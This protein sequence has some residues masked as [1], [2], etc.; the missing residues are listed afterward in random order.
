MPQD[1]RKRNTVEE[2]NKPDHLVKDSLELGP[3]KDNTERLNQSVQEPVHRTEDL[4]FC[5]SDL[6]AKTVSNPWHAK[7]NQHRHNYEVVHKFLSLE[8]ESSNQDFNLGNE[9][10]RLV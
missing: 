4:K 9:G 8:E 3:G 7:L 1:L 10:A 6:E 5:T 2:S